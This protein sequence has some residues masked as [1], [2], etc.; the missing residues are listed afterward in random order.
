M[1][2]DI[3]NKIPLYSTIPYYKEKL[4]QAQEHDITT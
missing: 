1:L 2:R 3:E 4:S